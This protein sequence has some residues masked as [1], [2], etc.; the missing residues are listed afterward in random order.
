VS[1]FLPFCPHLAE[2][3][4]RGAIMT[5]LLQIL[6]LGAAS[7]GFYTINALGLVVVFRSSGIIN[8]AGGATAMLGG[9]LEWQFADQWGWPAPVAVLAAVAA[10]GVLGLLIF[11]LAI[12]P[13]SSAATLTLV[14]ATLAVLVSLQQGMLLIFGGLPKIPVSFLPSRTVHLGPVEVGASSLILLAASAGLTLALWA[15]YRWT[16][17]GLATS[18]LA[19]APRSLASLG[20]NVTRMRAANWAIGGALAGLAGAALGPILQLTPGTFTDLLIPTLACALIGELRSFPLTLIGGLVVGGA[21]AVAARYVSWT[22]FDSAVPFLLIIVVLVIRGRSLPL[23]NFVHERLPRVGSGEINRIALAVAV[24]AAVVF[25]LVVSEDWVIGATVTLTTAII[26]LSQVVI[27]GYAGQLSLA[28]LTLGGVGAIVAANLAASHGTPFLVSLL[29]GMLAVIPVS[30]GVGLPSVRARGISLAIVTLGLAVTINAMVLN[31]SSFTG[32][33][34]GLT[35]APQTLFGWSID[36]TLYPRRYFFV[37]LAGFVALALITANVRRGRSGR[38][39]LAV[40]NNERA[41]RALGIDVPGAKLYAFTLAGTIA[42]AGGVLMVFSE[43]IPQ[44]LGFDPLTG[45]SNLI[46]AVLGG[47]GF[48]PGALIGGMFNNDGLPNAILYPVV[49]NLSWWTEFFPLLIGVALVLQL[50]VSPDGIAAAGLP[51]FS[52]VRAA[53][54]R[55]VR[56]PARRPRISAAERRRARFTRELAAAA[57]MPGRPNG[58]SLTVRDL[59][60]AFGPTV[61]LNGVDIDVMPGQVLSVI[62]PN[63]AGKTTLLDAITGFVAANGAITLDG[64]RIDG[65]PAHRRSRAGIARSFQSLELFEDMTVMDN[66]RCAADPQDRMSMLLDLFHPRRG[67]LTQ[68]AAAAVEALGLSAALERLPTEIG[69]GDRR[70]VAIARA[71]AGAPSVLLLDEPA[72]GLSEFER[73]EVARSITAMAHEWNLA[74]ILIEHDVEL[75]RQVSDRVVALNFGQV[76]A[77]GTPAQVLSHPEVV[78]AYLGTDQSVADE[79][80]LPQ[81]PAATPGQ[82]PAPTPGQVPAPTSELS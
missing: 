54:R 58:T 50:I 12:R 32:G 82:V 16:R 1:A 64:R 52:R 80:P 69:Y 79:G 49:G 59:C 3:L 22:G 18:A 41:A 7:G 62:G 24:A 6:L 31:D 43:A 9:Y 25:A 8:F 28:Q 5:G 30:I 65:L 72:A 71:L 27:T 46:G 34:D 55:L 36:P 40:R 48:I 44:F 77:T 67:T 38:R 56:T 21:Q 53:G 14:T 51:A 74:V 42:A 26:L 75:V 35:V 4:R 13:L 39:L 47:I 66:L 20:W 23:R 73:G 15:L 81:V 17:F 33:F 68:A 78:R 37:V 2:R 45:L 29:V 76:I 10:A 19:E 11:L 60:V 70:L 63:G 61:V 57:A